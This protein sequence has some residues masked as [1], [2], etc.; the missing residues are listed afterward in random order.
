MMHVLRIALIVLMVLLL[1]VLVPSSAA[2]GEV[3]ALPIDASGGPVPLKDSYLSDTEY[4][5]ESLHVTITEGRMYDT[6]WMAATVTIADA[7]QLRT[8]VAGNYKSPVASFTTTLAKRVNAVLALN[9]DYYGYNT[10]GYCVRQGTVIRRKADGDIDVLIIDKEGNFH[11][12]PSAAEEECEAYDGT[13]VNAF[14]FGPALVIDGKLE[15]EF[16]EDE[17][18]GKGADKATQRICIAQTG[19]LAYMIIYCEGPE[20]K[21]STGMTIAQFAELVYS[22]GNIENAYNLD[23]GSSSTIVLGGKKINGLSSKKMR[24]ISDIIYFASACAPDGD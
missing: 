1:A 15:T 16:T 23:G 21:G 8:C 6:N 11:I 2:V 10:T 18:Y 19:P 22:F 17:L 7:S 20:N 24:E 9:G 13:V 4:K 14:N 5:D 3:R 12:L